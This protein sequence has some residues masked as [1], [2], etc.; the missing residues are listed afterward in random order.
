MGKGP[1]AD[2]KATRAAVKAEQSKMRKPALGA[3]K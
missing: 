1:N 2:R 3:G